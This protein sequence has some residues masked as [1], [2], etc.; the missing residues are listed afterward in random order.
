LVERERKMIVSRSIF[1]SVIHQFASHR[2]EV[3]T[4]EEMIVLY[5]DANKEEIGAMHRNR[6]TGEITYTLENWDDS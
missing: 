6:Q 5:L 4:P 1:V 3:N 2:N